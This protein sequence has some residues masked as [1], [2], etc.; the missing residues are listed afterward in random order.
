MILFGVECFGQWMFESVILVVFQSVFCF[1][2][3]KNNFLKKIFL[4]LIHQNNMKTSKNINLKQIK[5]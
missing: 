1:E 4:I 5:K 2:M 3:Y